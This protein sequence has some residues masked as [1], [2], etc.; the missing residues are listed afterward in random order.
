MSTHV[1]CL[2]TNWIVYLSFLQF[3]FESSLYILDWLLFFFVCVY[4]IGFLSSL[5]MMCPSVVFFVSS[6]RSLLSFLDLWVYSFMKLDKILAIVS[7]NICSATLF[8]P[9]TSN[10]IHLRCFIVSQSSLIIFLVFLS[11]VF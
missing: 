10:Y 7:L 5:I 1:F 3:S 2:L 4:A 11:P 8:F 6:A 9:G